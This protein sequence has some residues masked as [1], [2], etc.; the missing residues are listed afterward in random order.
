MIEATSKRELN[1]VRR[2]AMI[3][4]V[5]TRWFL[6]NGYA[7]TSMSAI[8][9]E[10]GG[11]KATLWSHF[12]S[13]DELFAAVVDEL[14]GRFSEE[15]SEFLINQTFSITNLKNFLQRFLDRMMDDPSARLFRLVLGEGERFPEIQD[16]YWERGPATMHEHVSDFY[17]TAFEPD[18]ARR[19]ARVTIAAITGFRAQLLI[20]PPDLMQ[21]EAKLFVESLVSHLHF[22]ACEKAQRPSDAS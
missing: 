7:A 5:A 10:I 3:V 15:I 11:S 14:I 1:K 6:E 19:L 18:E 20:A 16:L 12:A 13:K 9:D 22:P 17:G 2:R 21:S 4:E 8:A